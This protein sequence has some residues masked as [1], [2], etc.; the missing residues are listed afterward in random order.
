MKSTDNSPQSQNQKPRT[1][2]VHGGDL[3]EEIETPTPVNEATCPHTHMS[4]D[5]SE[6]DFIA[7]VCDNPNCG[8]VALFDK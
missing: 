1:D 7:F 4:R 3:V 6:T 2:K 8:V 5:Y